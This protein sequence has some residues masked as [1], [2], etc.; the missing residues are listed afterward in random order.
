MRFIQ[1]LPGAGSPAQGDGRIAGAGDGGSGLATPL[2][3]ALWVLCLG[4][5]LGAAATGVDDSAQLWLALAVF[6]FLFAFR[7]R[8]QHGLWRL[9]YVFCLVFVMARYFV[10]RTTETIAYYDPFSFIGSLALYTA[11]VASLLIGLLGVL[12]SIR[13]IDRAKVD[14]PDAPGELPSVDVF[15]PTYNE[16]VKLLEPTVL[17]ACALRYPAEKLRVHVLDDGGTAQKLADP[18]PD[19]ARAAAER[20]AALKRLCR[21]TGATYH[22][23]ARNVH[24]KAG[25]MNA[26]L[27]HTDGD[28]ILVLDAD[29]IP[30]RDLLENTVGQ[31]LGDDRLFMV[32]TPHFFINADP[33]ER[34]LGIFGRAP[35]ESEMFFRIIQR[36][37]DFWNATLFAGSA[38]LLRR[39]ALAEIGGFAHHTVTEDAETA[40]EL[41]ARGWRSA[42]V[43]RPMVAGL[44]PETF[45]GFVVQRMRWAQGMVQIFM[46]KRPLTRPGLSIWQRI[47]YLSNC[48][49]WFFPFA[50]L[51]FLLAPL[52]YLF[53]GL[54]IYE[55]NVQEIFVYVLPQFW[56]AMHLSAF[57]FGR[58]RWPFISVLYEMLQSVFSIGTVWSVLRNPR[59]PSFKVTPKGE[60]LEDDFVSPLAWPFYII[61]FVLLAGYPAAVIWWQQEP[62]Y[63]HVLLTGLIWHSL[64]VLVIAAALGALA[65]RRQR[66]DA[67]RIPT[68][69][70]ATA[71]A[72]AHEAPCRIVDMSAGGAN[73]EI[74]AP[75][76]WPVDAL[77]HLVVPAN[78]IDAGGP[79]GLRPV[80]RRYANG[81]W[82]LGCALAARDVQEKMRHVTLAFGDSARWLETWTGRTGKPMGTM[83]GLFLL[84]LLGVRHS[85]EHL[86]YIARRAW[87]ALSRAVWQAVQAVGEPVGDFAMRLAAAHDGARPPATVPA[88][89][90]ER[91]VRVASV[92]EAAASV[93]P[94]VVAAE[95][96][97]EREPT[98]TTS[99]PEQ[100]GRNPAATTKPAWS[101]QHSDSGSR[102]PSGRRPAVRRP[103]RRV[104]ALVLLI[105]GLGAL[106]GIANAAFAQT[107]PETLSA[108]EA[109]TAAGID[110]PRTGESISDGS[111]GRAAARETYTLALQE[112]MS[113]AGPI[114]L[115]ND[116]DDEDLFV[117]LS[118]RFRIDQASV[119]LDFV[120]SIALRGDRSQMRVLA[121]GA[122]VAQLPLQGNQPNVQVEAAIDP[123]MLVE[124]FNQLRFETAQHYADRCEDPG[125]PELWTQIDTQAS[126]ISFR[127][128]LQPVAPLLSELDR[129]ISPALGHPTR[130]R[131]VTPA[132]LTERTLEIGALAA[133]A[134]GLRLDYRP[135]TFSHARAQARAEPLPDHPLGG[136][137]QRPLAGQDSF[138]LGTREDLAPYLSEATRAEIT[139]PYLGV[140]PQADDPR[141]LI[142]LISGRD[143][144]E[145]R[146][147]AQ[148]LSLLDFPFADDADMRVD[149]QDGAAAATLGRQ[150]R[151]RPG[152]RYRWRDLGFRTSSLKGSNPQAFELDFE[153]PPDFY[154]SEDAQ[155]RLSLS[156]A[157]GAKLRSD[158]VLNLYL[159][160]RFERALALD[161]PNGAV[162][163]GY[164]VYVPLRSF[165]P[166][167]NTIQAEAVMVPGINEDCVTAQSGNLLVTLFDTST[168]AFPDAASYTELP[169]FDLF[170]DTGFPYVS[171]HGTPA[172]TFALSSLAPE[173]AAS[174]WTLA[175]K[176][177]QIKDA[178]MLDARYVVGAPDE[179]A[180]VIAVGPLDEIDPKL[181][182]GA[183]LSRSDA[184]LEVP[185]PIAETPNLESDWDRI[186]EQAARMFDTVSSP[187]AAPPAQLRIR[188]SA[189]PQRYGKVLAYESAVH[190][191]HL[192]TLFTAIDR[193]RLQKRVEEIVRPEFWG[194]LEGDV[195]LWRGDSPQVHWLHANQRFFMGEIGLPDFLRYHLSAQPY[196]WVAGVLATILLLAVLTRWLL[197]RLGR[198]LH[199]RRQIADD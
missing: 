45:T 166:G 96:G 175:G 39:S 150:E 13:P 147:A 139:G 44:A 58:V 74:T 162:L 31:F 174:A 149:L 171:G 85:D 106:S 91:G 189:L 36:G 3:T 188:Q 6:L 16:S 138:L 142:V 120:N 95:S 172:P 131:I 112:L 107:Q 98:L 146:E 88:T 160:D 81:R 8:C 153:L 130:Y 68:D 1:R 103:G 14:L 186:R 123:A 178:P 102:R 24:A 21:E 57:L 17:A 26:A 144:A 154:V 118:E 185:Y 143:Q 115:L 113:D 11:E 53:F 197:I 54:K 30:T 127:G 191:G 71:V 129:L 69:I 78:G 25:N 177:A 196:Y 135:G 37:L 75:E 152:Q 199:G 86:I 67:P 34:N 183:A 168:I 48:A 109:V 193:P 125:A 70:A 90:A 94:R 132:A 32:Q 51:I 165:R 169:N 151:V 145:V 80:K 10:W 141:Y 157:Y 126:A 179:A 111:H 190:P 159:N 122:V 15:I 9:F 19:K 87:S 92:T 63:R 182:E 89:A 12:V 46:L 110:D 114:R 134:V 116:R 35:G 64:N 163:R 5:V 65:E 72:G 181:L 56:A 158:S 184:G 43:S 47:C 62:E 148:V 97:Q 73:V 156:F 173:V 170:A 198:K 195:A 187:N 161:N 137:D 128:Q 23:R 7:N 50:R 82:H 4:G 27:P 104:G 194:Q 101:R 133:Q 108:P 49:Y 155:V 105:L 41:H 99:T 40:L 59:A 93:H 164:D 176:M 180:N 61:L 117:P 77:D 76:T 192:V 42:F 79:V 2:V 136:L 22:T 124:G 18:D 100:A 29:H 140:Y 167:H 33:I 60:Q 52:A 66:R 84:A 38:A 121:N 119:R 55:A 83:R 28:L 20:A